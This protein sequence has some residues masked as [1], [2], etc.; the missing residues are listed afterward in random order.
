MIL[1]I[2]LAVDFNPRSTHG[3]FIDCPNCNQISWPTLAKTWISDVWDS[4]GDKL[5]FMNHINDGS[6][7]DDALDIDSEFH[8]RCGLMGVLQ[9]S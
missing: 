9:I 3:T 1:I 6:P 4:E 8:S 2:V 5:G 7:I